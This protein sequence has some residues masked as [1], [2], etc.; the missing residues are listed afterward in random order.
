MDIMFL[1]CCVLLLLM[2]WEGRSNQPGGDFG[3]AAIVL[4]SVCLRSHLYAASAS[5]PLKST[6]LG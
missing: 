5:Q 3:R 4:V 1:V 2:E 6:H